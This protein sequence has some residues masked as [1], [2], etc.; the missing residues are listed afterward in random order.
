MFDLNKYIKSVLAILV[1]SFCFGYFFMCSI[2]N[3]KTDPQILIAMVGS[4]G[5]CLGYFFGSASGSNKATDNNPTVQN[6]EKVE[7]DQSSK[8]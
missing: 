4:L 2:R 3:I 5:T 6:A 7:I 8:I 1:V